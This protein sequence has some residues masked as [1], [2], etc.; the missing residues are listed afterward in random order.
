MCHNFHMINRLVLEIRATF[1]RKSTFEGLFHF[2]EI[3]D[4]KIKLYIKTEFYLP[5]A[6]RA[7]FFQ[8][9]LE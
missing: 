7:Y 2:M 4:D 9:H 8:L 6:G 5:A 3:K 1:G